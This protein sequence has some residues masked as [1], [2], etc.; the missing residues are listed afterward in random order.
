MDLTIRP[1]KLGTL[2]I[3]KSLNTY[4]M[5]TGVP[6]DQPMMAYY[7]EGAGKKILVDTGP[8]DPEWAKKI[9][10][11]I[12]APEEEQWPKALTR[13][14][15][16]PEEI[17]IVIHTHLHW[18]HAFHGHLFKNARFFVQKSELAFAAAPIFT[19]IR[20]YQ[21]PATGMTPPYLGIKYT[22][23]DGD[24]EI[25][26]GV[27]VILTPGH[28]QGSQCV[29]VETRA[30]SYIL[31]NDTVPLYDNWEGAPPYVPHIPN[32]IH[33]NLDEYFASFDKIERVG[34]IVLPGHDPRVLEHDRYPY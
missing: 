34:G 1:I 33:V 31:A 16:A 9:H 13:L 4:M 2:R 15:I 17:D 29:T 27:G 26:P 6:L 18:D 20:G 19:Q 3:D 30:G 25:V 8:P 12:V 28:S 11:P 14:G 10:R 5:N 32:T 22:V 24:A 21:A 7:I 23:L